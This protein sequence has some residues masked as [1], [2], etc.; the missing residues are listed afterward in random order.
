MKVKIRKQMVEDKLRENVDLTLRSIPTENANAFLPKFI[1]L[2]RIKKQSE[3]T[4]QT[5]IRW[6]IFEAMSRKVPCQYFMRSNPQLILVCQNVSLKKM[7]AK[8]AKG[9]VE[10]K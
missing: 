8:K 9:K 3:S 6:R 10:L 1:H 7:P 2:N 5:P 4:T